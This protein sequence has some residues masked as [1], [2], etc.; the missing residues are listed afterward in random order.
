[1]SIGPKAARGLGGEGAGGRGVGHVQRAVHRSTAER[2]DFRRRRVGLRAVVEMAE[3]DVGAL[4]REG[5]RGGTA[6]AARSAGDQRDLS[7]ELHG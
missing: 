4:G 5:E 1:M 3:R 2:G 7:R 6:D